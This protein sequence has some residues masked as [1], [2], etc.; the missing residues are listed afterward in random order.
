M[1][2]ATGKT[3]PYLITR[4]PKKGE[5][6][7][8]DIADYELVCKEPTKASAFTGT[9][10]LNLFSFEA[11]KFEFYPARVNRR[12]EGTNITFGLVIPFIVLVVLFSTFKFVRQRDEQ[13]RSNQRQTEY[14][15]LTEIELQ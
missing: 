11:K 7:R 15:K 1:I 2:D 6:K 8:Y 14:G 10:L 5:F 13:I 4:D 12:W 3:T 9:L